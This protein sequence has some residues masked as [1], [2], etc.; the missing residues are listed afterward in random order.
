ME[1]AI[2]TSAFEVEGKNK[3]TSVVNT[4]FEASADFE[5]GV[6]DTLPIYIFY[7]EKTE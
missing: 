2:C 3:E 1:N 6:Y 5:K 4:I 7:P